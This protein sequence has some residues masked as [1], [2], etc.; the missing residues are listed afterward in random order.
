M[1]LI[2][3]IAEFHYIRVTLIVWRMNGTSRIKNIDF[4]AGEKLNELF[5]SKK[6]DH[7][8][9]VIDFKGIVNQT[10]NA[11]SSFFSNVI[12]SKKEIYFINCQPFKQFL[13]NLYDE[14]NSGG[15]AELSDASEILELHFDGKKKLNYRQNELYTIINDFLDNEIS[16]NIKDTFVPYNEKEDC[17]KP[18][19]S[20][21]ILATGQFD[22]SIIISDPNQFTWACIRMADRV[23]ELINKNTI[24]NAQLLSVSLR[25]SPFANAVSLL[26]DIKMRTIDHLG[27]FQKVW[28][29]LA[30]DQYSL[31]NTNYIFIG[32]F[33]VGGTELKLAHLFA[34]YC[35]SDLKHAVVLGSVFDNKRFIHYE[36]SSITQLSQLN[37]RC[38]YT[39][40]K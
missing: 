25:A 5:D 9:F 2:K 10:D 20:T 14:F 17:Y 7:K 12:K 33:I 35:S 38:K 27:P 11:L 1:N 13:R 30:F 36:I 15:I 3:T 23:D 32:D 34:K 6:G 22:A 31:P 18:L 24:L 26:L 37:E 4:D 40:F 16:E 28:D 39:L 21:P 29:F 19:P 8:P